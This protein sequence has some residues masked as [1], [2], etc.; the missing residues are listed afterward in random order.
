MNNQTIYEKARELGELLKSSDEFVAMRAAEETANTDA[1]LLQ[2]SGEF[3]QLRAQM[4]SL[5]IEDNP[6]YDKIGEVSRAMDDMQAKLNAEPAMKALRTTRE[7]FNGLMSMVNRELQGVL[8]PE[9]LVSTCGGSC[10]TCGGC[11]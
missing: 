3:E 10:A 8:A 5:T 9:S 1:K 4:Q 6:D 7:Q 2:M 11:H